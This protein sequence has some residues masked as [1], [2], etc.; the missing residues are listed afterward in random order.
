M[1][2]L[3]FSKVPKHKKAPYLMNIFI[4]QL[5]FKLK[6]TLIFTNG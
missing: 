4:F 3:Q 1:P 6:N 5:R 2:E